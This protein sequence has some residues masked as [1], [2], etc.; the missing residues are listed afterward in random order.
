MNTDDAADLVQLLGRI[1]DDVLLQWG[2][3]E[4]GDIRGTSAQEILLDMKRQD[5]GRLAMALGM[6]ADRG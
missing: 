2:L 4:H 5:L 1:D 6:V 3:L